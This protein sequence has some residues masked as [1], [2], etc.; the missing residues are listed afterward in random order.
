MATY[1][2]AS[3]LPTQLA[4]ILPQLRENDE[5]IVSDDASTDATCSI[6]SSLHD[7]RIRLLPNVVR[8]GYVGNFQRALRLATGELIFFCDQDDIWAPNKIATIEDAF[9][10]FPNVDLVHHE[11]SLIDG[12][13][14]AIGRGASAGVGLRKGWGFIV[15]EFIQSRLWGCALC[16]RARVAQ[17]MLPFPAEVYGHDHWAFIVAALGGGVLLLPESL[18]QRRLHGGNVSPSHGFPWSKRIAM[19]KAYLLM[20]A[21]ALRRLR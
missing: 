15:R 11:F 18:I 21:H 7:N 1:N 10:A 3:W 14:V 6:V 16:I 5:L 20:V 8:L 12:M 19:R 17:A 9:A 4:S 2:G 13:G